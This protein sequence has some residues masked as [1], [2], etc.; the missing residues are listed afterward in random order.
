MQG[1]LYEE[2]SFGVFLLV[3]L[4]LGGGTAWLTGRAIAI[5]WR[6]WWQLVGYMLILGMAVRFLHFSLFGGTLLSAYFYLV[7]TVIC[8]II[9]M[10]GYGVTRTNQMV[11]QYYWITERAGLLSWKRRG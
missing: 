7:D 9:S 1:Y 2:N 10:L 4:L 8:F 6:P 11:T 5:T 3:T